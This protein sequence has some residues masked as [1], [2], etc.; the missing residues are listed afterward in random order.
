MDYTLETFV[1]GMTVSSHPAT[2]AWMRG[3]RY[4]T[5]VKVG[6][7]FVH[8]RMNRSGQLRK[9]HPSNLVPVG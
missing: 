4:G 3:D 9:F 1:V 2:D 8:V 7:K 5:V 6:R